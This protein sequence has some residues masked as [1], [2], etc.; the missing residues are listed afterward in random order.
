MATSFTQLWSDPSPNQPLTRSCTLIT[1]GNNYLSVYLD[2]ELRF[3]S[4]TLHLMMASPFIAFLECQTSYS[5]QMLS[6]TFEDFYVS[7]TPTLTVTN[8]PS[9]ASSVQLVDSLGNAMTAPVSN[10]VAVLDI[11]GK[12]FPFSASIIV[13]DSTGSTIVASGTLSLVGG[14][15]Y[16]VVAS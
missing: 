14:D 11:G 7:T 16:T 9:T 1:N 4:T 5:G 3:M 15:T 2:N 6:G 13:K 12:T 10:G 8:L